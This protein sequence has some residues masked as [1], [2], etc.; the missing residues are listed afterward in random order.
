MLTRLNQSVANLPSLAEDLDR[1]AFALQCRRK[2][3]LCARREQ[4]LDGLKSLPDGKAKRHKVT[5][6]SQV[7]RQ[8]LSTGSIKPL[9]RPATPY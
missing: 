6:Q 8:T 9:L 2:Q 4:S 5:S 7:P 1:V 3:L